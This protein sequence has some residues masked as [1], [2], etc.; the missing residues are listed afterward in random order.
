M[1]KAG[2]AGLSEV[3]SR[4]TGEGPGTRGLPLRAGALYKENAKIKIKVLP[5]DIG[6]EKL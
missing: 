3:R 6:K 5:H 4:N 2:T 1:I